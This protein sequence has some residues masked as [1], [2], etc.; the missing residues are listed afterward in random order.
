MKDDKRITEAE[1][2]HLQPDK[3]IRLSNLQI[4]DSGVYVCQAKTEQTVVSLNTVRLHVGASIQEELIR[5]GGPWLSTEN[6]FGIP[7]VWVASF[8]GSVIVCG[9]FWILLILM[10]VYYK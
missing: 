3:G 5:Q 4:S 6:S 7:N 9:G 10:R 1:N 2:V 8:A